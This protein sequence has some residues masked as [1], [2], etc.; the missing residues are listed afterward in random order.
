MI[1]P[2]AARDQVG[3]DFRVETDA[4][5]LALRLAEVKDAGVADGLHQFSLLFHGPAG[6]LLPDGIHT[7]A[8]PSLGTHDIF[9]VP[10]AGSSAA[11]T[12]YQA[13]FS[14]RASDFPPRAGEK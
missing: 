7:F 9:V 11:R 10:V 8:H 4:G 6:H 2:A 12:I 5:A 14:V 1:D 3:T 13:C